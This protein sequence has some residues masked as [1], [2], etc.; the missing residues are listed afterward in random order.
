MV[1]HFLTIL[2]YMVKL[3]WMLLG[4]CFNNKLYAI[5]LH[6]GFNCFNMI[7]LEML[8]VLVAIIVWSSQW[9][10]KSTLIACDN[11]AV[12]S[13]INTGKTKD[14]ILAA[15]GRNI[16]MEAALHDINL[17]MIHILGKIILW[18]IAYLD[19]TWVAIIKK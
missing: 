14:M 15:F 10:N 17:K 4:A 9:K 11:Q 16:A 6:K 2:Q 3:N 18:L 12:V 5:P 13:V 8:N 7:H 1:H 19:I